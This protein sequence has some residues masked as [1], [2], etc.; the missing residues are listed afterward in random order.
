VQLLRWFR[1]ELKSSVVTDG[2]MSGSPSS[3]DS[4]NRP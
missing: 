4:I 2:I 1:V 3:L